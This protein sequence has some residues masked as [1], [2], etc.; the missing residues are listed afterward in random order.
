[1]LCGMTPT[2][3]AATGEHGLVSDTVGMFVALLGFATTVVVLT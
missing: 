1:M 3:L 2:L